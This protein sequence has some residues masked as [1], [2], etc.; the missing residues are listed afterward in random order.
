MRQMTILV[1]SVCTGLVLSMSAFGADVKYDNTF[2]FTSKSTE[3]IEV[4]GFK[5][6]NFETHG[7]RMGPEGDPFRA[8]AQHCVGQFTII[9]GEQEDTV[10]CEAANAAGD[11]VFGVATR[12]FDTAKPGGEGSLRILG[13]TGK[14][15]GISGEG[16]SKMTDVISHTP[17]HI[18]GCAHSWGTYTIK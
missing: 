11:K 5:A 7:I 13:G 16:K 6:G 4:G 2:C 14:F 3:V 12:K 10:R 9:N 15:A 8:M 17:E 18:S 1:S